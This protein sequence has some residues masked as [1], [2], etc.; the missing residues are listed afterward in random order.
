MALGISLAEPAIAQVTT[1]NALPIAEGQNL[2]RV[3][4][5][6]LRASEGDTSLEELAFPII[7]GRGITNKLALFAIVPVLNRELEVDGRRSDNFG[8]GDIEVV[9][10][11]TIFQQNQKGKTLRLAPLF[12][13]ELPTGENEATHGSERLPQP[14]QLGS[15]SVDPS[16]GLVLTRQTLRDSF[17]A[18]FSYQFNTEANDFE[19]GD[20]ATLD[21]A[22]K[23]R[24]FP[25]SLKEGFLFL[26]LE[27]NLSWQGQNRASGSIADNS[28]GTRLFLSPSAQYIARRFVVEGAVQV[29]VFQDLKGNALETEIQLTL[30]G[31]INF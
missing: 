9:A 3:Q 27:S 19:F 6:Y 20:E 5:R 30:G 18:S 21:L 28:G 22:Y 26:G 17:S 1:N 25:Q 10:R 31:Q 7:L 15:G 12:A 24:V 16:L 8:L 13:L 23:Y 14:L 2:I 4:A 11:Y 29:P